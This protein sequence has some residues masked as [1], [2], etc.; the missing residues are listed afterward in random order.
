M[1]VLKIV[2]TLYISRK[3]ALLT[4]FILYLYFNNQKRGFAPLYF[5]CCLSFSLTP[6]VFYD[7]LWYCSLSLFS[8][9]LKN[10]LNQ[11]KYTTSKVRQNIC[12]INIFVSAGNELKYIAT[13]KY[14]IFFTSCND[15]IIYDLKNQRHILMVLI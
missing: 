7:S 15:F 5:F 3:I 13:S 8:S 10:F 14:N 6:G 2:K 4:F 9:S 12:S 11:K 1:G